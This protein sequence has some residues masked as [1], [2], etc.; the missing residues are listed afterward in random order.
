[1]LGV[2]CCRGSKVGFHEIRYRV[3]PIRYCAPGWLPMAT[4]RFAGLFPAPTIFRPTTGVKGVSGLVPAPSR[5]ASVYPGRGFVAGQ[6][7]TESVSVE[8]APVDA[9]GIMPHAA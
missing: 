9:D 6:V 2:V 1:M 3:V 4:G 5:R 8:V 7:A